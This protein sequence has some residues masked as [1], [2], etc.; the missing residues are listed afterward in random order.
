M[1]SRRSQTTQVTVRYVEAALWLH[2]LGIDFNLRGSR[3]AAVQGIIRQ[4]G[5]SLDTA[6]RILNTYLHA[7]GIAARKG[8]QRE[9]AKC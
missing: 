4:W 2:R 3:T 7:A 9:H 6:W 8:K 5:V 1:T